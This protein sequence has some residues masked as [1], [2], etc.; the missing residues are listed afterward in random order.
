[1]ALYDLTEFLRLSA[2]INYNL[3]ATSLNR[4]NIL[5]F[6]LGGK[7]FHPDP[8]Q[9]MD[10]KG[11]AM[12][13]LNYLLEAYSRKR[14]QLGPIAVL[15]PLRATAMFSSAMEDIS[16]IDVLSLLFHDVLEDIS[17]KDFDDVKW[18]KMEAKI[19][20]LFDRLDP[21]A[22]QSLLGRLEK[23]TKREHETYNHY[24]WRLLERSPDTLKLIQIKLADRL[25]NTLDMRIELQD[26]LEGLDF[27]EIVF[28]ILF[29]SDYQGYIPETSHPPSATINGAKRLYQLFKNVVLLSLIR[30][31]G[32][33]QDDKSTKVLFDTIAQASL[34]EAQRI[35]THL[36]GYHYTSVKEQRRLLL[37]AMDYCYSGKTSV[38][39]T[40]GNGLMMDGLFSDYFD[41]SSGE[42]RN[43]QLDILYENKPLM[44]EASIAFIVIF[45]S[46]LN[47]PSFYV[48]GIS[49]QG[50]F[51]Q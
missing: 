23:L 20:S 43:R 42:L 45:S 22:E 49:A 25:D 17:P 48:R 9:D 11:V 34:K 44:I 35:V 51:P 1:M 5:E 18:R 21:E 38:I 32:V 3:S 27:Y 24:I 19:H 6:V 4:Y 47:D 40:P 31:K 7:S 29:V 16:L 33:V 37:D 26:P 28:E 2:V 46:F 13:A 12:E 39:T 15:H 14:R 36:M 10:K 50:T 8:Q 41:I 30:K